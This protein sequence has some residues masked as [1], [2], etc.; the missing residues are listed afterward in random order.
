MSSVCLLQNKALGT[1][2]GALLIIS[3]LHLK[4]S[5]MQINESSSIISPILYAFG[6]ILVGWMTGSG[7]TGSFTF[8]IPFFMSVLCTFAII[9]SEFMRDEYNNYIWSILYAIAW[10]LLGIVAGYGKPLIN[11]L[12]GF[13]AP[14]FVLLS[15]MVIL[16]AA[17]EQKIADSPGSTLFFMGWIALTLANSYLG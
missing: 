16:P 4:Y 5:L 6:W 10:I 12:F 9:L 7:M 8:S 2:T 14:A 15:T 17:R 11:K 3:A 1:M 13:A